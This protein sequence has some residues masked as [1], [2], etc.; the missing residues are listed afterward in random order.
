ML[1]DH[2]SSFARPIEIDWIALENVKGARYQTFLDIFRAKKG[3]NENLECT[4]YPC[5][6]IFCSNV[7][8]M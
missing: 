6:N 4:M 2:L 7:T 3:K 1:E 8:T 5:K